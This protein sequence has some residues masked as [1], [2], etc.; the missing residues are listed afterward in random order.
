MFIE[1]QE[2]MCDDGHHHHR[3]ALSVTW[4][5]CEQLL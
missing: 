1:E 3:H 5:C 2:G 4:S